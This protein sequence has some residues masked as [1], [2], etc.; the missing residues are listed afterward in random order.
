MTSQFVEVALLVAR[1]LDELEIPYMVCGSFASSTLGEARTTHDVDFVVDLRAASVDG[2]IA[3]L[4]SG[5]YADADAITDAVHRRSSCNII[6]LGSGIKVDL[7]VLPDNDFA[8]EEMRRRVRTQVTQDPV[9]HAM[10]ASA[11]DVVLSKLIWYEKSDRVS[12]LQWRDVVGVLK[13]RGESLDRN[14]M[15]RW[16]RELGLSELLDSAWD[17]AGMAR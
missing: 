17:E 10:L 5:F 13:L 15:V 1:V 9:Q 14:Y 7:F 12:N 3:R 6:H 16:A 8:R 2:L 11:E 4:G